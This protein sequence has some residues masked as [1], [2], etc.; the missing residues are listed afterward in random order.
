MT[1]WH[2]SYDL[3]VT[4]GSFTAMTVAKSL[5]LELEAAELD[6]GLSYRGLLDTSG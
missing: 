6:L 2:S 1:L 4:A 5:R 3:P